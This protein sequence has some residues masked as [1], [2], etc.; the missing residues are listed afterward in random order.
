MRLPALVIACLACALPLH[1]QQSKPRQVRL[2]TLCFEYQQGIQ[3]VVLVGSGEKPV[4]TPVDLYTTTFSDEIRPSLASETLRFAVEST[5]PDG[6]P[7][8]KTVAEGKAQPGVRQLVL[9]LPGES[10]GNPYRIMV[11]DDSEKAFPLGSSLLLNFA[12]VAVRFTIGEHTREVKPMTR[13]S[14]PQAKQV[15]EMNQCNVLIA[16][17]NEA[18]QWVPVNN[19]RWPTG[20]HKRDLVVAFIHPLTKQPTVNNYQDT[21]PWRLPKL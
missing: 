3:K 9:F 1:A 12:P 4:N 16:F 8:L 13:A 11:I 21:P 6:K 15:N 20:T 7:L 18:N 5:G 19:T 14:L 2:R 17:A 10:G